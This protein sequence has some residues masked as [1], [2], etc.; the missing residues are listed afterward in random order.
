MDI[1]HLEKYNTWAVEYELNNIC[2]N[3]K[4]NAVSNNDNYVKR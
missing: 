4:Q 1:E 3:V 2:L